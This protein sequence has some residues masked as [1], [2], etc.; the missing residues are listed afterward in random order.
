ME[1]K[2][3]KIS[4]N[5]KQQ[6]LLTG[7]VNLI[8]SHLEERGITQDELTEVMQGLDSVLD[9]S[10]FDLPERDLDDDLENWLLNE[11]FK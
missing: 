1:Y 4:L 2:T 3:N 10:H 11:R 8:R 7:L 9:V 6:D 5:E